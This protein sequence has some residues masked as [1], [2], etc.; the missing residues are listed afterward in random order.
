M[1]LSR[2]LATG[3][4]CMSLVFQVKQW[5]RTTW[6][7]GDVV[8][9]ATNISS[10]VRF[11][12]L[13]HG[14]ISFI[15]CNELMLWWTPGTFT[16]LTMLKRERMDWSMAVYG[17]LGWCSIRTMNF[18][19]SSKFK[20]YFYYN[21]ATEETQWDYPTETA[22]SLASQQDYCCPAASEE[23]EIPHAVDLPST[24]MS[25]SQHVMYG[26]C[27]IS[28]LECFWFVAIFLSLFVTIV[29]VLM[30]SNL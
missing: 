16:P 25:Y 6:L 4:T 30:S 15:L 8:H 9:S 7:F 28:I 3:T 13:F 11:S 18:T 10:S 5:W 1:S 19:S 17:C 26:E 12:F 14:Q 23:K 22:Q 27:W 21:K 20:R 24:A 29:S 2:S